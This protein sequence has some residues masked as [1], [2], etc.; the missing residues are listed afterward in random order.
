M[1]VLL[2]MLAARHI[3]LGDNSFV[4]AIIL[5]L[6]QPSMRGGR[7]RVINYCK[8]FGN[9]VDHSTKYKHINSL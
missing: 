7:I 1:I 3:E 8:L 9:E 6:I 5:N 4:F 2:M